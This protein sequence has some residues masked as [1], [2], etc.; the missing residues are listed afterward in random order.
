MPSPEKL[1]LIHNTVRR[2][3]T[4]MNRLMAPKKPKTNLL[5]AGGA[6]R[7]TPGRCVTVTE[8]FIRQSCRELVKL[9]EQGALKVTDT[10]RCRVDIVSLMPTGEA[11]VP[12]NVNPNFPLDSVERD[13]TFEFGVGNPMPQNPGRLPEGDAPVPSLLQDDD[14]TGEVDIPAFSGEAMTETP[15][16]E[17]ETPLL[18]PFPTEDPMAQ[19]LAKKEDEEIAAELEKI[20]ESPAPQMSDEELEKATAPTKKKSKK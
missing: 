1:F 8:S 4:K 2:P 15:I 20:N 19:D 16:V 10:A 9:E 7:V 6:V 14:H 12:A 11:P 3:E 13:Q 5:L 18:D 17:G